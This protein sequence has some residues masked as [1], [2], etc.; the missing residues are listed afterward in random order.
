M[1]WE[2]VFREDNRAALEA[3]L[4]DY[5]RERRWFG[6]KARSIQAVRI[7]EAIPLRHANST[8]YLALIRVEYAEGD[9]QTYV[10]PLTFATGINAERIANDVPAAIVTRLGG[11]EI[12]H[13]AL[14]I[15]PP[16]VL[17][18]ATWDKEFAIALL[19][20]IKDGQRFPTE[21]GEI[22]ASATETLSQ[23]LGP[24]EA[25]FEPSVIGAEQSNTSLVYGERFILKL[26]RRLEEG[27]SPDLE[28]GRFLAQKGF[29][30]MP[31]VVGAIEYYR[32][33]GE[34]ITL[35]IL[36]GYVRN[37]GDAWRYTLDS[38]APYF[39]Q[40]V[41]QGSGAQGIPTIPH[42][43]L[44]DLLKEE[45]PTIVR[46]AIGPYLE[47]ARMLGR[48]TAEMHIALASE[49]GDPA[50][51]PEPFSTAYQQSIYDSV[52]SM[53]DEAL[54]LLSRQ[55]GS[56]PGEARSE[57]QAIVDGRSELLSRMGPLLAR[58]VAAT[59]TRCHGDYHLGQVL[60]TGSDFVIIDFEGEPVRPL[61]ERRRKHSPFKDVGGMLRSFHYAA[62]AAL[63]GLGDSA[64][65]LSAWA[66][67]WHLWVSVAYLKEYLEVASSAA[68]LPQTREELRLL[69]D[70]YLL[71]KATYELL[72]ELN[73]RPN[74]VR[75]PLQGIRQL[76][77]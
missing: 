54:G 39:E 1:T 52:V 40:A 6:G 12:T 37:Q 18:D 30:H 16:G 3:I 70:T 42:Q 19:D 34:P 22:K 2:E 32:D 44:L 53:A 41:K 55:S 71:E 4:P 17:Y 69:L 25:R 61:H 51:A 38:L 33:Q 24:V 7:V 29:R 43:H 11:N 26:F 59:R 76:I 14:R 31:P 68:F 45:T 58:E 66:D 77:K 57:A 73:N 28:V 65:Y 13:Y 48:R 20:A 27:T 8:S 62:Y 9:P 15:T 49:A 36:Q 5:I 10:L 64:P 35:A 67:N 23:M 74:W 72:Y 63:M 50:F 21:T 75:I 47:S 60:Y 46:E 56:L